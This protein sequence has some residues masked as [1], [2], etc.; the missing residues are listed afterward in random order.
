MTRSIME[1]LRHLDE[2]M[3]H[4]DSRE[5]SC[6]WIADELRKYLEQKDTITEVILSQT[7][8]QWC[9]NPRKGRHAVHMESFGSF[10]VCEE[11]FNLYLKSDYNELKDRIRAARCDPDAEKFK[12]KDGADV[13]AK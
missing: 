12:F 1:L 4:K 13:G 11:C 5:P 10:P 7:T 3:A 6:A 2:Q 9:D 8:C